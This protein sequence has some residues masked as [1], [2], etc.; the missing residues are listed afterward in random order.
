MYVQMPWL[1]NGTTFPMAG[2]GDVGAY[3]EANDSATP[4]AMKRKA[5]K[6]IAA[7][8]LSL[9]GALRPMTALGSAAG[10][11]YAGI[12]TTY[13]PGCAHAETGTKAAADNSSAV[14]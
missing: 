2:R 1:L 8:A 3:D 9:I 10:R 13:A 4:I 5:G 6:P 7:R 11:E 14:V 12:G